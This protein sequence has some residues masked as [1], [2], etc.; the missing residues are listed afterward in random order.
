M[1]RII[2]LDAARAARAEAKKEAP[3][4]RFGGVDYTLPIELPWRIV[5]AASTQ[6]TL[7][8]VSA[9]KSLL[10]DQWEK[11]EANGVSASDMTVLIE[12]IAS[13]YGTDS[14]N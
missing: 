2:D 6:D 11:F 10:G 4:I 12:Q 8:I 14:G 7:Q 3:I 1:S 5:E 13:I 9:I